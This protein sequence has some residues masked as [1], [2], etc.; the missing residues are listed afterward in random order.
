[1]SSN[2]FYRVL[3]YRGAY[4]VE[5]GWMEEDT[6]L[7]PTPAAGARRFNELGEALRFAGGEYSEYGVQ[8]EEG[9]PE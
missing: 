6:G 7:G 2:N 5:M 9:E 3:K 4:Y 8:Y 1:M